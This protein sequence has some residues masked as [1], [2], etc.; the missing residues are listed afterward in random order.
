[1]DLF[2]G[3]R[4]QKASQDRWQAGKPRP[5]PRDGV[6]SSRSLMLLGFPQALH[7]RGSA[8][9]LG[10]APLCWKSAE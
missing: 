8:N 10:K 1:V 4:Q 6:L 2:D 9:S 3:E 5:I 7:G